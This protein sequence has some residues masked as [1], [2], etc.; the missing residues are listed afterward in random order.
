VKLLVVMSMWL[1][2]VLFSPVIV[3]GMIYYTITNLFALGV[4]L[5]ET[6]WGSRKAQGGEKHSRTIH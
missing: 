5:S 2:L 3:L 1:L 6:Y 4:E